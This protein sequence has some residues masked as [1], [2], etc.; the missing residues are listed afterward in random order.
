MKRNAMIISLGMM[1]LLLGN[2]EANRSGYSSIILPVGERTTTISWNVLDSPEAAVAWGW[3]G[4]GSWFIETG[5]KMN[6]TVTKVGEDFVTGILGIGNFSMEANN[7]RIASEIVYGVWG[8]TPFFPGLVVKIGEEN[9]ESLNDTAYASAERVSGNYLNGTMESSYGSISA[10][11]RSYNCIIFEYA[12]DPSGFGDPQV[13]YLAYDTET[14]VLVRGNSSYYFGEPWLPYSLVVEL[15][16]I[17]PPGPDMMLIIVGSG[18]VI[19]S[20]VIVIVTIRIRTN[21]RS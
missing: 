3:T 18:S 16:S 10:S 14:G 2:V 8:L 21:P 20:I 4:E 17:T 1:F 15:E 19:A 5:D 11:G 7:S 12:Q 13:T 9:L 6:F